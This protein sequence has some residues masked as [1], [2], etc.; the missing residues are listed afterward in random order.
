MQ[1]AH[2]SFTERMLACCGRVRILVTCPHVV[3]DSVRARKNRVTYST[4][5]VLEGNWS[6]QPAPKL[7]SK[8]NSIHPEIALQLPRS[9]GNFVCVAAHQALDQRSELARAGVSMKR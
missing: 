8:R 9:Q 1:R 2:H 5:L 3:V 7:T 4:G 6:A